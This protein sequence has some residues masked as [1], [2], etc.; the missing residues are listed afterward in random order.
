MRQTAA[1]VKRS[2]AA[3]RDSSKRS[4]GAK[5]RTPFHFAQA[6]NSKFIYTTLEKTS[7]GP[8]RSKRIKLPLGNSE[9]LRSNPAQQHPV[10]LACV[11]NLSPDKR[12]RL[13]S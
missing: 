5:T 7:E 6:R 3:R 2:I 12:A 13:S 11:Q 9:T 10:R 8:K 1:E 4:F